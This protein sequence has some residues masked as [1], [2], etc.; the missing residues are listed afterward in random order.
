[1]TSSTSHHPPSFS[2]A[3]KLALITGSTQG[4]GLEIASAYAA[5]GARVIING[6]SRQRVLDTVARLGNHGFTAHP[7]VQDIGDLERL[8]ASYAELTSLAGTPDILVNN[9]GIRMRQPLA[10]SST[11]DVQTLIRVDL[12][13]AIE[14]SRLSAAAM[15]DHGR[16]GRI[17]TLTSIAGELA[18]PGDAIYPIAKQGLAGLV[19]ALAV[20]FGPAGITSNGIAPGTFATE[21]NAALVNDPVRGPALVGRNPSG[22]W[23]RP[24]EIAGAAVFL[25]SSS[26]SYVNG[27]ILVVD[28]GY[29]ITF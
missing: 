11:A 2:L 22:R 1:M 8:A 16:Q 19:R 12:L 17:I 4:L 25:A 23:G 29:S 15:R 5:S 9:V 24:D 7:Y 18:N 3:G 6:R 21:T 10:E 20:E 27:H 28:G 13:A 26:A 14:L